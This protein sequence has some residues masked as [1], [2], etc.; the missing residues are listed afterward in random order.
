MLMPSTEA[1]RCATKGGHTRRRE[2]NVVLGLLLGLGTSL[3]GHLCKATVQSELIPGGAKLA[4]GPHK[5]DGNESEN[6]KNMGTIHA[7]EYG[8]ACGK[9]ER[10]ELRPTPCGKWQQ[11]LEQEVARPSGSKQFN[12]GEK[13]LAFCS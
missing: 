5:G 2:L 12:M 3:R 11:V 1:C 13:A 4:V 9:Q 7:S 6:L 10:I 8:G